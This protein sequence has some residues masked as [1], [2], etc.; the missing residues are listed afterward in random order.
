[1]KNEDES[2][3]VTGVALVS[4][5]GLTASKT[6]N[7]LLS[8][9]HGTLPI[10]D[11]DAKGF[12][13]RVAAQ[14]QGLDHSSLDVHPRDARIMDKHS[15]MLLKCSR[16]AFIHSSLDKTP[17]KEE[18]IGFFVGMGMVD[19]KVQDLMP[20]VMKSLDSESNLD[21]S[22]FYS[23][24]YQE[25]YPLWPLSMLNNITFCQVA[26]S[27]NLKGENAVFSP[28]SDSG[29]QAI[30]EGMNAIRDKRAK[31][32]L[33][34]GVSEKVSPLSL[35]RA[36]LFKILNTS[37]RDS[38]MLC[39]PF[40]ANRNGTILGEG[41]GMMTLESRSSANKRGVQSLAGI[42]GYG[43]AFESEEE[44]SG[45]TARAISHAMKEAI[46]KAEIQSSD[47]D[48]IIVHGDGTC[49]GDKNEIEAIHLVFSDCID[50]VNVYSSKGAL[51][52]LLAGAAAVDTVLGIYMLKNG[53]IP[54]TLNSLLS[55]K[56]IKFNLVNKSLLRAIPKRIMVNCQSYEGQCASLI[57]EAVK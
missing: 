44:F 40:A 26:I 25:I 11:F 30:I 2:V 38:E 46:D 27:L 56:N 7:A 13:C 4:S 48:A 21:Y 3:V 39:R 31:A 10:K 17:L 37:E 34:G 28:H 1:M 24:G 54:P 9:K 45:P 50:T 15:Y 20:S 55:D 35:A 43:F 52:H 23:G 18:D 33:A 5:L 8:G 29:A 49:I 6:W 16:D 41:C 32:V 57:I 19:Y 22:L 53:V 47:I 42:A 36:H 14:V 51:G 12:E